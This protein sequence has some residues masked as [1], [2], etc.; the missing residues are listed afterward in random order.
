[1]G[2]LVLYLL[3]ESRAWLYASLVTG[4]CGSFSPF[5]SRKIEWLWMKLADVLGYIVP[6]ILMTVIYIFLLT[7]LAWLSRLFSKKDPLQLQRPAEGNFT[8]VDKKFDKGS[9]EKPW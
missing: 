6:N 1:V 3:W 5:L 7:P 9:L 4:L 2:F 8:V